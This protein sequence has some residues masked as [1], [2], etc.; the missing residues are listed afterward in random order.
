MVDEVRKARHVTRVSEGVGSRR[1]AW[2]EELIFNNRPVIIALCLLATLALAFEARKLE[3]N[4]SFESVIPTH[5]PYIVNFLEHREDLEGLANTLKIVVETK[6][7]SIFHPDYFERLKNINDEV[8]LLPGV[9]RSYMKSLWTPATRWLAV[10]EVGLEGGTVIPDDY[11]GSPKSLAEVKANIERSGEIGQLV[12]A[13]FKSSIILVPLLGVDDKTGT[14]LD[15]GRLSQRLEQIRDKYQDANFRIHITGFAKIVGDLIGGIKEILLF[16]AVSVAITTGIVFAFTR[17][18]RSTALVVTC[19]LIAVVWQMGLLPVL[20]FKLDP[21]SVLVPFLIFAIGMSHGAQKMNGVMQDIGRGVHRIIAA[22]QTF[23]RLFVAGFTA[24]ICDAVGFAVLLIIDIEAIRD[25]AFVASLGVAVLIFTNLILLPVLLSYTGVSPRAAQRSLRSE[26]ADEA[27]GSRHA[28]WHALDLFTRRRNA[29]L[30]LGV[31]LVLGGAGYWLSGGLKIGDLDPGAP[32]LRPDS[33]Y[34]RDNAYLTSNYR[35]SSDVLVVMLPT[36][37]GQCGRYDAVATTDALESELRQLPSVEATLSI[38]DLSKKM[39]AAL[40]EGSL[41]WYELVPNQDTLNSIFNQAPRGLFNQR[42]DLLSLYVFLR[43]HKADTLTEVA[44]A[45]ERFAAGH[46]HGDTRVLLAA[47]NSGIELA[48]NLVVKQASRRMLLWV[49]AAVIVLSLITF[50]SWRAV[51]AA[52][53]PLMLTSIL[54]EALMVALGIGVKVATLPVTALG[55]GIGV[56]YALYVLSVVLTHVRAGRDLSEAYYRALLFTGKVVMLT[57]ATISTAVA[58]WAF[59]PIKFQADMGVLLAFMF[60]LNM[61]GAL[62]LLPALACFLLPTHQRT[63]SAVVR[64]PST[65]Q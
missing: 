2:L 4:A 17:C 47:G 36:P 65:L 50:R 62:V 51:L 13:N 37:E 21:Y 40:S 49:Y 32:E 46:T 25:L 30:S 48:T 35:T 44:N 5:H 1:I 61:L 38:A 19:S 58:I 3:F 23:R 54:A 11:D 10:T 45:T 57:G 15:Y 59:S 6:R 56:D 55:V 60:L 20:G 7:D 29:A 27:G 26:L 63:A 41:L 28:L 64:A 43:D 9:N 12:A 34:N 22:R 42:C 33:R 53:L 18:L 52:I 8:F 14:S 39:V 16:F 24:L 31:A